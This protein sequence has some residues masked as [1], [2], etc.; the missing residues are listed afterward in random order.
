MHI[1]R[2]KYDAQVIQC[3]LLPHLHQES[4]VTPPP[5]KRR[6]IAVARENQAD[7]DVEMDSADDSGRGVML[8][9]SKETYLI[10]Q[11]MREG[12]VRYTLSVLG[13]RERLV[14]TPTPNTSQLSLSTLLIPP[15]DATSETQVTPQSSL[16]ES[17]EE[18][19]T[20]TDDPP[21]LS[22]AMT[23]PPESGMSQDSTTKV[24][25][26]DASSKPPSIPCPPASPKPT[27][28]ILRPNLSDEDFIFED[29]II[30]IKGVQHH[31]DD[32]KMNVD[33]DGNGEGDAV[34]MRVLRWRWYSRS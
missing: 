17:S 29:D 27:G 18:R 25:E 14:D 24:K 3:A 9:T 28:R 12:K 20:S 33:R 22:G 21:L 16:P 19:K 6:R 4:I 11:S 23:D 7:G 30:I 34:K 15:A 1:S 13:P 5:A 26:T 32:G 8:E 10:T 31:M 2:F